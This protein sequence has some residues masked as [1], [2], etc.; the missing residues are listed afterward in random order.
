MPKDLILVVDDEEDILEFIR[1][2]LKKDG[3]DVSCLQSGEEALSSITKTR[4]SLMILDLMLPGID[5]FEVLRSVKNNSK[6]ADM[7]IVI[8]S[9][10]G[11]DPDIVTG[12]ELGADDYITKPFSPKVLVARVRRILRQRRK[13]QNPEKSFISIHG[14]D[15][16]AKRH[17]VALNGKAIELTAT[18][19]ALIQFLARQPG[20][21]FT[22]NQLIDA[23]RGNDCA[24]TDRS[25]DV[26]IVGLR[27]K[28]GRHGDLIETV[29]GVGYRFKE[30]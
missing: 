19:F 29:H 30:K 10:K 24:V 21:V 20:W 26:H 27:K 7:S 5:G 28:M 1:Y 18:E 3:Y 15:I 4:P 16:D 14:L 25:V 9:A 12:L 13:E 17:H 2:N 22:R 8:L 6:T 11:E 23:I